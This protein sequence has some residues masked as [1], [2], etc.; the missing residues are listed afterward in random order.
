MKTDAKWLQD[1]VDWFR[2]R[3]VIHPEGYERDGFHMRG[4][5][6]KARGTVRTF[7]RARK[8]VKGVMKEVDQ[9]SQTLE[10]IVE[11]LCQYVER[12]IDV[13]DNNCEASFCTTAPVRG[14]SESTNRLSASALDALCDCVLRGRLALRPDRQ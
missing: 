3:V 11:R 13:L 9:E 1:K 4:L 5:K 2:N 8:E 6:S 12:V 14:R 10:A 7:A